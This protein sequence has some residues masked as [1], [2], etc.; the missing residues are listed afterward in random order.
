MAVNDS[1][2]YSMSLVCSWNEVGMSYVKFSQA[3]FAR[4]PFGECRDNRPRDEPPPVPGTNGTKWR[5]YCGIK[6]RKAG[7]SQGRVAVCPEEGSHLSEGQF[8][9]V[10]D[11]VPPKMFMFIGFSCPNKKERWYQKRA[12]GTRAHSPKPPFYKTALLLPRELHTDTHTHAGLH[13]QMCTRI[14]VSPHL[15]EEIHAFLSCMTC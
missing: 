13:I 1:H 4:A 7:L 5:F 2:G 10:P 12:C 11:T 14:V 9:F 6:Q 3:P 15:P 8:L